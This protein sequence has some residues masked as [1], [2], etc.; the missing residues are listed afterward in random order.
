MAEQEFASHFVALKQCGFVLLIILECERQNVLLFTPGIGGK[1]ISGTSDFQFIRDKYGCDSDSVVIID[2]NGRNY[3]IRYDESVGSQLLAQGCPSGILTI[4]EETVYGDQS[5]YQAIYIAD[6]ENTARITLSLFKDRIPSDISP[7]HKEKLNE[8]LLVAHSIVT[9]FNAG[10]I[11][12]K[13]LV[14]KNYK[15]VS[16]IN[17]TEIMATVRY[18]VSVMNATIKRNDSYSKLI[19]HSDEISALWTEIERGYSVDE[20]EVINASE[21]AIEI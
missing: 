7:H 16:E 15:S 9:A 21:Q 19:Y 18:G 2:E 14:A 17:I 20:A 6:N 8:M 11:V 13:C 10:K 4:H 1:V 5:E 3:A 12:I